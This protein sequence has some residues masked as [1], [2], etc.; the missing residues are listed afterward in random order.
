MGAP[1]AEVFGVVV[2]GWVFAL[3]RSE[4]FLIVVLR[5]VEVVGPAGAGPAGLDVF[6]TLP[7][8]VFIPV[9]V[10]PG[11]LIVGPVVGDGPATLPEGTVV[12]MGE[13]TAGC[14]TGVTPGAGVFIVVG[15]FCGG[16][17]VVLVAAGV[18]GLTVDPTGTLVLMGVGV[19]GAG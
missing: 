14:L 17:T 18:D 16:W 9:V 13:T 12:L 4:T 5:L 3:I 19:F 10:A 2:V 6:E 11:A 15:V 7:G 8:A 1:A